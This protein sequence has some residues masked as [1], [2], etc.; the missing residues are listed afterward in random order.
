MGE[1]T[2]YGKRGWYK[3]MKPEDVAI[4]ERFIE[5]FPEMYDEVEYGV[6]VGT[7]PQFVSE[8]SDPA[9]QAQAD[10]YRREID[11][12]GHKQGQIDIIELKPDAGTSALGQV[13]GYVSLYERDYTPSVFPKA[14]VITDRLLPDMN[15]L[16]AQMGVMMVVV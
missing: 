2:P 7:V 9:M 14:I 16:A 8:H 12:I 5:R 10:I 3:H 13:R 15:L 11:V 4:W 1:R 6:R